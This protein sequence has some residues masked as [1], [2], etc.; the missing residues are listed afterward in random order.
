MDVRREAEKKRGEA[1]PSGMQEEKTKKMNTE[2]THLLKVS[3]F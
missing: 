2:D 1:E 3:A